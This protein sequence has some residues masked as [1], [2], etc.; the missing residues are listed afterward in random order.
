MKP[1]RVNLDYEFALFDQ[2][3]R[4]NNPQYENMIKMFEYVFFWINQS[5]EASLSNVAEYSSK[6]IDYL[7]T[8]GVSST[9]LRQTKDFTNWWG[10]LNDFELEKKLNSKI[11]SALIGKEHQ[12]G[13]FN[14]EIVSSMENVKGH[15]DIFEIEDWIIKDPYAFSGK[16]FYRFQKS[17][18]N[19]LELNIFNDKKD[20]ILEPY[21]KR[22]LD[23]GKTYL[24]EQGRVIE[25]FCVGSV[26]KNNAY[27]GGWSTRDQSLFDKCVKD[28]YLLDLEEYHH[29]TDLILQEYLKMGAKDN[30]Q[31]D[32]F[33]YWDNGQIKLYPLVEV[34]YRK[35]MG[36]MVNT[37]KRFVSTDLWAWH[38]GDDVS[39]LVTSPDNAKFKSQYIE[40][41]NVSILKKYLAI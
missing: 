14:G 21:H 30:V 28:I 39:G 12:W 23:I 7:K 34:N 15:I 9:A 36:L 40:F 13:L 29:A 35:T 22:V 3:Y 24:L 20:F 41:D 32:S 18:L 27:R 17:R 25:S 10:L 11:T 19:A 2:N 1:F 4:I 31:I 16:G 26:I 6:Y 8:T 33:F 38:I 37:G 5:T